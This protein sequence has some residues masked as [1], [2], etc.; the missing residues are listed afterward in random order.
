MRFN[1]RTRGLLLIEDEFGLSLI[2]LMSRTKAP[3]GKTPTIE[4]NF[5]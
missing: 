5:N 3:V 4:H 1:D 2:L